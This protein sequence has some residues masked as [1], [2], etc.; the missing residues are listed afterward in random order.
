MRCR[1]PVGTVEIYDLQ[2]RRVRVLVD[3]IHDPGYYLI[4]WDG[5]D[6]AGHDLGSGIYLCRLKARAA[7]ITRYS[8]SK[9]MLLLK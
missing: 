4:P 1:Q 2:G 9:Q 7:G 5:R 3:G 6:A 8:A